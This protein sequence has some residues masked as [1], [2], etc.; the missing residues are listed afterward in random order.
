ME[1]WLVGLVRAAWI[2]A[3]L[4]ILIAL[5]PSSSLRTVHEALMGIAKRGKTMQPSSNK[6]TVPQRFFCHFYVLAVVWTTLLL[7][8]TWIYAYKMAPL[9][10]EPSAVYSTLASH[11]T[12][13]SHIFSFQKFRLTPIEHRYRVWRSVFLLLLIEVQLVRRL[14]E[15]F[16]VFKYSPSARMHIFGYLAGIFYY[17]LAPLSLC[18]TLA[19]EVFK[20]AA[21]QMAAFE[22]EW[23]EFVNPLVKLGWLQW[24]GAAIFLWGWIH[25][26]HCHVILGSLREH[27]KQINEYV[28]PFGDWFELVSSPHYL[29]EIVIYAGLLVASGG[30]DLT[31]WL[32]FGFVVANLAFA[33]ADTHRWYLQ[34]FDN[35]PSN[36]R[37]IVPFVY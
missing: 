4:P 36:R 17:A 12:G 13:G 19:P 8:M 10:S 23:W 24:I 1:V 7:C 27:P 32:L 22:F 11:L 3:T 33:A 37:A 28:I 21:E 14:L 6:F 35:Y 20:F 26:H 34:K 30:A 5:I 29:A 9:I 25:Q 16:Y 18:C 15:S 31:I 2:A